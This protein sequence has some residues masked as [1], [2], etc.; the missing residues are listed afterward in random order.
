MRSSCATALPVNKSRTTAMRHAKF[1]HSSS[2]LVGH[3]AI[4]GDPVVLVLRDLDVG[5]IAARA[6]AQLLHARKVLQHLVA[7]AVGQL[8][9]LVG[10]ALRVAPRDRGA[11]ALEVGVVHEGDARAGFKPAVE[12]SQERIDLS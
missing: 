5:S 3:Y 12:M 4:G 9:A 1:I 10:I 2:S 11:G 6:L 7:R 8:T